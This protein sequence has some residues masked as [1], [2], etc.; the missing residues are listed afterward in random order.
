ME[1]GALFKWLI[2][3]QHLTAFVERNGSQCLNRGLR[4]QVNTE[5]LTAGAQHVLI[6]VS[7]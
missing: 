2:E 1:T 5:S 6:A 3:E 7:K 4:F